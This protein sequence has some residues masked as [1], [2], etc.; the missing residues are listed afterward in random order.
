VLI[1]APPHQTV[2]KACHVIFTEGLFFK[3]GLSEQEWA[4]FSETADPEHETG[5]VL[6]GGGLAPKGTN[7]TSMVGESGGGG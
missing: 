5:P 2:M 1:T 3:V 6:P 4:L 7:L